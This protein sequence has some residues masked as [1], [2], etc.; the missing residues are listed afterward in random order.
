MSVCLHLA[1]KYHFMHTNDR[2]KPLLLVPA[3]HDLAVSHGAVLYCRN[4]GVIRVR[5]VDG[6]YGIEC[7]I[8]FKD[9]LHEERHAFNSLDNGKKRCDNIF[10]CFVED[11][12]EIKADD[13][14]LST[15]VPYRQS[16]Q[17]AYVNFYYSNN[18]NVQYT[19]DTDTKQI[20]L[21]ELEIPNP[22]NIPREYRTVEITMSFSSTEIKASAQ[23]K[24]LPESP[25]VKTV[26]DF[27]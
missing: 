16:D 14:F 23:A 17:V 2:R 3:D 9:G 18:S 22:N 7:S 8:P 10:K 1:K 12:E 19:T 24:Y 26:L 20:G 21:I 11:S 4:P 6:F 15:L 13:V 27:L 5:K 25:A